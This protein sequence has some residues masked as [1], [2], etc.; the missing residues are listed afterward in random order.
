M[1]SIWIV[2]GHFAPRLQVT[3]LSAARHR[4]NVAV[5]FFIIM[6]GF[7]THWVYGCRDLEDPSKVRDFYVRRIGRVVLT[8]WVAMCFGLVV[9]LVQLR[10]HTP[11]GWHVLRCFALIEPW[12]DPLDWC[13]NGQTWTV[14]ALVPSWLL[15]PLLRKALAM[16]EACGGTA[17][18]LAF[19]VV[20]WALSIGPAATLFISQGYWISNEQGVW[21]YVWPPAQL[22]DFALGAVAASVALRHRGSGDRVRGTL[23]DVSVLAIGAICLLVPA[24]GVREG[25]EPLFNHGL[26]PLLAA[27]LYGS[28]AGGAGLVAR[29]MR[30]DA[31]VG[32]G[33]YSFEVYLF[34]HPLHELWVAIG[35]VSGAYTMRS[36]DATHN[37]SSC[38]FMVFLLSLWL[39]A[40]L[41]A[42]LVEAHLV[43]WLREE[44]SDKLRNACRS[45][46]SGPPE[47]RPPETA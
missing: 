29:L 20:L 46:G 32:L 40:G 12:R 23:A 13:P 4:G 16:V 39:G 5:D 31:L 14:A 25:G 11:D 41:Y 35:D 18:L 1:A 10:G 33:A 17:A 15:Y 47:A 38:A 27:F 34:Q 8:T 26:A 42:E 30:H 19:G 2:C 9:L 6:S 28:A 7:V 21:D 22:P 36:P 37:T 24:M 43:R 3:P 45:L 44:A